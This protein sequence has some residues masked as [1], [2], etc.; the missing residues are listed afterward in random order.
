MLSPVLERAQALTF[1]EWADTYL[2]LEE[3]RTLAYY[4]DRKLKVGHLVE[5]FGDRQLSAI[6]P[7]GRGSI[8]GTAGPISHDYLWRVS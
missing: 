3:V 1:R 2:S 4:K 8:S 6:T 5:F 7:R